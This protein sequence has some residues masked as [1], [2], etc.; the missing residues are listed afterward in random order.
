LILAQPEV[1]SYHVCQCTS[2]DVQRQAGSLGDV[3][4]APEV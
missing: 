2:I 1:R 4:E 3:P